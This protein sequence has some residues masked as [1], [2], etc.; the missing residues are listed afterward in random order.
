MQTLLFLAHRLPYPPNKGDKVRSYHFLRHLAA[1]YRVH[2][3]TFVD[4]PADWQH[5]D[6]LRGMVASLHVEPIVRWRKRAASASAFLSGEPISLSYFRSQRLQ[7]WA[8]DTARREG[9]RRVLG[10]SSPMAQYFGALPPA[11]TV[12]DFVDLDSAKWAEYAARRA[13]PASA[14]YRREASR[15]QAFERAAAR[16]ADASLFVT[17]EEAQRFL[18]QAPECA[19]RVHTVRNG[20]DSDYFSPALACPSP[21]AENEAA[22]VFTGAMDY[23]PN[24]DAAVWFAREVL[25][26][27]QQRHAVRFYIVGMNPDATVRALASTP[28]VVVTGRVPDVRPYLKHARVAVA[29]LRVARGIQNKVL[30]AMAMAR[31]IVATAACATSLS[32]R[33][34]VE[35]EAA[36][37]AQSFAEKTLA[38]M[39]SQRA[40]AMGR[41]AREHVLREYAWPAS[42][43]RLDEALEPPPAVA[44]AAAR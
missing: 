18:A 27:V 12:L 38:L 16:S 9:I 26:I 28:G 43:A 17:D 29:P 41:A 25:P 30:E 35:L 20:V 31:P 1:R 4:D 13:W 21:F 42:F 11:R 39:D 32:A 33:A 40:T 37:D 22:I 5:V 34:G 36:A 24:I 44:S 2:L 14:L 15:L 3:G 8:C 19:A 6:A 10:F 23:W 7:A